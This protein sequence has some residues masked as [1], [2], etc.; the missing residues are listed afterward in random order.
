MILFNPA[1]RNN[2][3]ELL[4]TLKEYFQFNCMLCT[5]GVICS[6]LEELSMSSEAA[7]PWGAWNGITFPGVFTASIFVERSK[8]RQL[9]LLQ[10][11]KTDET[12]FRTWLISAWYS[13]EEV[14]FRRTWEVFK[15]RGKPQDASKFDNFPHFGFPHLV[16]STHESGKRGS[17]LALHT[18]QS[19]LGVD[20]PTWT[21]IYDFPKFLILFFFL[22]DR[23][24]FNSLFIYLTT[25]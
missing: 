19:K 22:A 10:N 20:R 23:N 13:T 16:L 21:M 11:R 18:E 25:F 1:L 8:Y 24:K 4:W 14:C 2:T 6:R 3:E 12:Y 7:G 9:C 5:I 15:I 17:L